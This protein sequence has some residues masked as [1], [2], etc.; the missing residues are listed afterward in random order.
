MYSS[1][2]ATVANPDVV[3]EVLAATNFCG[4]ATA[5]DPEISQSSRGV[6]PGALGFSGRARSELPGDPDSRS[7]GAQKVVSGDGFHP[8]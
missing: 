6:R 7:Q 8:L 4:F 2:R 1:K 3:Q 5:A